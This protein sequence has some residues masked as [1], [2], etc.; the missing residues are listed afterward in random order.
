MHQIRYVYKTQVGFLFALLFVSV[1]SAQ[2]KIVIIAAD[3]ANSSSDLKTRLQ[4]SGNFSVIDICTPVSTVPSL[5]YLLGYDA[6]LTWTYNSSYSYD[7]AGYGNLFASYIDKGK[8][9]VTGM[10]NHASNASVGNWAAYRVI[11]SDGSFS[12]GISDPKGNI[13]IPTDPIIQGIGSVSFNCTPNWVRP[14]SGTI[15]YG[16]S[17]MLWGSTTSTL[18][19]V[20]SKDGKLNGRIVDLGK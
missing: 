15:A 20:Y 19:G 6:V 5:T 12:T 13:R 3:D 16:D 7:F 14:H 2:W 18:L 1:V 9:V 4:S 10:F 8:G 11:V 17:T